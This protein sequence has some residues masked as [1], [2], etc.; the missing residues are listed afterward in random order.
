M[1]IQTGPPSKIH[2]ILVLNGPN[3]NLLGRREPGIYGHLSLV[4]ID[5][6]LIA[7]GQELGLH[8]HTLQS[9]HEGGLMDALQAADQ[10]D[11]GVIL[12]C[13]AY[14]HTSIAIRDAIAAIRPPVIEVHLSNIQA[15]ES[16]RH[17]SVIA[18]V[19]L[20]SIA[21]FGWRS[22]TLGLRALAE[23]LQDQAARTQPHDG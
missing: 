18:P 6:R 10:Q 2:S 12:N 5:Q 15:R 19:C 13:G 23:Y 16:F 14:T 21:G 17:Q 8:V 11:A 3:L 7:L 1:H 22:Y 9:N 20:G 4:E